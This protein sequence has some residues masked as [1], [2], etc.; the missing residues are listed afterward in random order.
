[1]SIVH[2]K[3]VG[4]GFFVTFLHH[5]KGKYNSITRDH[6]DLQSHEHDMQRQWDK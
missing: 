4:T 6:S 1:M 2:R 3:L 5:N